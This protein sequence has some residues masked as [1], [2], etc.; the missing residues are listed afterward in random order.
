MFNCKIYHE[1]GENTAMTLHNE[2]YKCLQDI[3]TSLGLTYQQVADM[4]SRKEKRNYQK[5]KYFP[6]IEIN[7]IKKKDYTAIKV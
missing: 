1:I 6:Q 3:A 5:F 4:S 2:D 7:R